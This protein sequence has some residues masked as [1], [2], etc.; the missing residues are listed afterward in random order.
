MTSW[1]AIEDATELFVAF[2]GVGTRNAQVEPG[3][4]GEH[5]TLPWLQK[6]ARTG[7]K[8]VSITP[9]RDDTPDFMD[10]EWWAPRPNTDVALMMGLAH[11]LVVKDWLNREFLRALYGR[12]RDFREVSAG[13]GRWDGEERRLGGAICGI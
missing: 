1:D 3:G 6:L 7:V 13:Q 12:L 9:L 5:S 8:L 4:M 11:T 2:G 10:A